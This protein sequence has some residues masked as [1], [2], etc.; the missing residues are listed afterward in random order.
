[1]SSSL[2]SMRIGLHDIELRAEVSTDLVTITVVVLGAT[3]SVR[4]IS[5]LAWSPDQ[6][7]GSIARA[8][9]LREIHGELNTTAFQAWFVEVIWTHLIGVSQIGTTAV[10]DVEISSRTSYIATN[11]VKIL[12]RA[13]LL[14]R[15]PRPS[16]N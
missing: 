5:V 15:D 10:A 1:M 4:S 16:V 3:R 7:E 9:S 14:N 12:R 8:P 2:E 11:K 6:V 13:I